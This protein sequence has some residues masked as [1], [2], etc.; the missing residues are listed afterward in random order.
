MKTSFFFHFLFREILILKIFD[1]FIY[2]LSFICDCFP[3]F[4]VPMQKNRRVTRFCHRC[5]I[6][7]LSFLNLHLC[8]SFSSTPRPHLLIYSFIFLFLSRG[9]TYYVCLCMV[10]KFPNI[11]C[12]SFRRD[13]CV[14]VFEVSVRVYAHNI[15]KSGGE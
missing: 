9:F 7:F 3:H 8:T 10:C 12:I 5:C 11:F 14:C 6:S 15:S 13:M 1:D 2:T 4:L